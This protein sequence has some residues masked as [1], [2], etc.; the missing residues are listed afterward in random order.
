MHVKEC[1]SPGTLWADPNRSGLP[2]LVDVGSIHGARFCSV[3]VATNVSPEGASVH[4]AKGE[5]LVR[6]P[7]HKPLFVFGN[8]R[9][10]GPRVHLQ[11]QAYRW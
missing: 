10:N 6:R 7:H 4:P 11:F 2:K 5:A 8:V 3:L 1:V 9:P